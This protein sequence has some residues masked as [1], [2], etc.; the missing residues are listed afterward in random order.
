MQIGIFA[1]TFSGRDPLAVMRASAAAGF[2]GVAYN[3]AC[4]GLEPMP[5]AIA[6]EVV[7]AIG[8]ASRATGQQILSLS[9]TY[10]MIHPDPAV[11]SLGHRRLEVLA[12]SCRAMG[13]GLITLCTGTRD[14]VDQWR[15]H[16]DNVSAAA[17]RDLLAAF[18]VAVAIAE[19][20]DIL[21]GVEPELA[22]VV[23]S[24]A[25]AR[26]LMDQ[27]QSDRIR[28]VLDPAN[29]VEAAAPAVRRQVIERAVDLMAGRIVMAHAKD[30]DAAGGFATAGKGVVDF[31]H[32]LARLQGVGF[33]GPLVT[34]GLAAAE[35]ADVAAFLRGQ[36]GGGPR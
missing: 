19:R 6:P 25:A 9:G 33:D 31:G 32:F 27:M 26:R 4:S 20:H 16:S 14:A 2:Q 12:A 35:A 18:E 10:N 28:I 30:R 5:E 13:T 15:H 23:N 22:N 8:E 36:L 7:A 34:H 21:L 29:L 1:K 11:R 24:A 17:W 3:M